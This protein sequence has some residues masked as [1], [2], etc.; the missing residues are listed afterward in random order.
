MSDPLKV[1][2]L[3]GGVQK[4]GTTALHR[5]LGDLPGVQMAGVK[6]TH[7]FDDETVDWARP[8]YGAY[9]AVFPP[10]D[11]RPRGEATPIYTYWPNCFERIR[12]Y[13]P[14]MKLVLLFRDPVER[15]W[16]QWRMEYA[17]GWE[18]EPFG[19]CIRGGRA[20]VD[21]PE[22]PGFHRV[23]SYVERGFYGA[24]LERLFAIFP[25][26]QVLLLRS[27]D[28]DRDPEA[29]LVNICRFIGA[30][31]PVGGVTRRRE[32]VG[33]DLDGAAAITPADRAHLR[34]IYAADLEKFAELSGLA[35]DGWMGRG[36][37]GP[38]DQP[39]GRAASG[40]RPIDA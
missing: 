15:A 21:S 13:N 8:D 19:W 32:L 35:V 5:Y 26:E 25:R 9:H 39:R 28:L 10:P 33:G 20:R 37:P 36:A 38:A 6:E 1:K 34:T 22:A 29:T 27:E 17:R 40:L 24:Q 11:G 23:F 16:S 31:P 14:A 4:G 7:F 18:R 3:I 2:F 12:R 30:A